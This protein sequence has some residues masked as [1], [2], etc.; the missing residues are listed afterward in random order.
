VRVA[1]L[2]RNVQ[3]YNFTALLTARNADEKPWPTLNTVQSNNYFSKKTFA[4]YPAF[5]SVSS[6]FRM[7]KYFKLYLPGTCLH[8][9]LGTYFSLSV[10]IQLYFAD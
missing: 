3:S 6:A 2:M 1:Y 10:F 5:G 4:I 7:I 9:V 8:R